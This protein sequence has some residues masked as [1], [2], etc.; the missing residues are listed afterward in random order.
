MTTI[1]LNEIPERFHILFTDKTWNA[2]NESE[3][4]SVQRT[5]IHEIYLDY[6]KWVIQRTI[7]KNKVQEEPII[8][9]FI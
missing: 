5:N 4:N 6:N 8:Q 1:P 7:N 2:G 9:G 3:L